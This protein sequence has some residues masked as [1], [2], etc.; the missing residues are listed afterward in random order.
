MTFWQLLSS[1]TSRMVVA[2]LLQAN[3]HDREG[4]VKLGWQNSTLV[5]LSLGELAQELNRFTVQ[6]EVTR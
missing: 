6:M 2:P 3:G 5:I 1:G 4:S